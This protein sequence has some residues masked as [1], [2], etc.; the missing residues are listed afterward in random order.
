MKKSCFIIILLAFIATMSFGQNKV[1]LSAE[2]GLSILDSINYSFC[3]GDTNKTI[4]YLEIYSEKYPKL[5]NTL[6]VN[7]CLC[8]FYIANKNYQTA[9]NK[10]TYTLHIQPEKGLGFE[11]YEG[12]NLFNKYNFHFIRADI[13]VELSGL[14]ETLGDTIQAIAYLDSANNKYV[15]Y[16]ACGNGIINYQAYLSLKY[17]DLFLKTGDTTKAVNQLLDH[18]I[19]EESNSIK[20]TQKLKQLLLLKYSQEQINKEIVKGTRRL[21]MQME[22]KDGEKERFYSFTIFGHNLDLPFDTLKDNKYY[23]SNNESLKLLINQERTENSMAGPHQ[24]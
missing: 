11:E 19:T 23:L 9:I 4:H 14:Y 18:F 7:L 15:N 8:K 13:C 1:S 12:C 17:A 21:K 5:A 6:I 16:I 22:Y 20:V 2:Y 3:I 24:K 10:L